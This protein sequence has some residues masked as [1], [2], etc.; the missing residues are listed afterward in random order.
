[1]DVDVDRLTQMLAARMAAI[2]PAGFRVEALDGMLW[3]SA[4]DGRF[5]GQLGD[6]RVGRAGSHVRDN[7]EAHG[8]TAGERIAGVA[9]QVLDE[10][11]DYVDE[12]THDPWP[13][14]RTPPRACAE[15][16]DT[17]VH[18]WYGQ[19]GTSG[20]VELACEPIPLASIQRRA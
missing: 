16:R 8:E 5:P 15:I 9:A 6:Y 10:L 14:E 2:V 19:P 20:H 13:G 1:M 11:Q 7:F 3:Y 18:L 12:A 4:E 17:L